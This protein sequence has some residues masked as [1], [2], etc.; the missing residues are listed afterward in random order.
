M[1]G[2]PV[3]C[4]HGPV[5]TRGV[6]ACKSGSFTCAI[7]PVKHG[8]F[9]T[10]TYLTTECTGDVLPGTE[11]CNGVDD[12]CDGTIDEGCSC[13][14]GETRPCGALGLPLP[15]KAGTQSCGADGKWG[16]CAGT[17]L[18]SAEACGDKI[19][20]NCNGQVDEYC[21]GGAGGSGGAAG[22]GGAGQSQGGAGQAQ[23]GAGSAQGGAGQAQGGAGQAQG[24]AGSAQGGAGQSQGGAGQSQGGAGQSQ[25]GAGSSQG[26]AGSSQGGAGSGQGGAGQ[27]QGG[28]GQAQGGAGPVD[29]LA[30]GASPVTFESGDRDNYFSLT[31]AAPDRVLTI[32]PEYKAT[33][34]PVDQLS[35][36]VVHTMAPDGS[37]VTS[38]SFYDR[39][40]TTIVLHRAVWMD[41][42]FYVVWHEQK[43]LGVSTWLGRMDHDGN[44]VGTPIQLPGTKTAFAVLAAADGK[45][46][47]ATTG[48]AAA[49]YSTFVQFVDPVAFSLGQPTEIK[50]DTNNLLY[51]ESIALSGNTVALAGYGPHLDASLLTAQVAFLREDGSQ[52]N[53]YIPRV[54]SLYL[55][56][57]VAAN[58]GTFLMC[59]GDADGSFGPGRAAFHQWCQT[60]DPTG[61]LG[62]RTEIG[63]RSNFLSVLPQVYESGFVVNAPGYDKDVQVAFGSVG[64]H[65]AT[66]DHT[67]ALKR[68]IDVPPPPNNDAIGTKDIIGASPLVVV[69]SCVDLIHT[70]IVAYNQPDAGYSALQQI[71]PTTCP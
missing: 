27:S 10:D 14:A 48:T 31:A 36:F 22:H 41:P 26:G 20:N 24:G 44:A 28:A 54:Q 32:L 55:S 33:T 70:T 2:V 46:V 56:A 3:S 42:Y 47:V 21:A 68:S 62:T 34:V 60:I 59:S 18:P 65:V 50:G 6:G 12:N 19:D 49:P 5:A 66:L 11:S 71:C 7:V 13:K 67:G 39:G 64:L 37:A 9:T 58:Q 61:Q 25:G 43:N 35:K 1:P 63:Y 30:P 51:P 23:G 53:H 15:C 16:T 45:V 17:V 29:C 69:G 4:Y 8:E 40:Q 52:F 38:G 57:M